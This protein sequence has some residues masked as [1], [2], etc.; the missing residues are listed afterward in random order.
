MQTRYPTA[1]LS[2]LFAALMLLAMFPLTLVNASNMHVDMQGHLVLNAGP[3]HNLSLLG[4]AVLVNGRDLQ[5][6]VAAA[7]QLQL[8]PLQ[9]KPSA[10]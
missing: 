2:S 3:G 1:G 6:I 4:D 10:E 8:Q 5:A 7:V 9:V